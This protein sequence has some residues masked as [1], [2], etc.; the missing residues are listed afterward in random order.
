MTGDYTLDLMDLL[1]DDIII[2]TPKK[3]DGIT[4]NWHSR[5][6]VTKVPFCNIW[7]LLLNEIIVSH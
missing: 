1:S 5:S 4:R 3:W 6:Y 7:V 2:S